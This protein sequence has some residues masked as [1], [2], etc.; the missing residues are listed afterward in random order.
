[1]ILANTRQHLTR[2]DAQLAMRMLARGSDT[3]L[4][5][6]EYRLAN[7]GIDALLDDPRLPLALVQSPSG[8]HASL[9]LFVYVMVFCRNP[10]HA[11]SANKLTLR[12]SNSR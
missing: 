11:S 7:D 8:G 10:I 4:G 5:E 2:N 12:S 1:M 6:L 9:P 3:E